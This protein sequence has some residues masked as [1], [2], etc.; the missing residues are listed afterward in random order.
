MSRPRLLDLFCCE[1]GASRGFELAGFQVY[2]VDIGEWSKK[3]E[4]WNLGPLKRYPYPHHHGDALVVMR[5]LLLGEAIPFTH[6]DGSVEWLTLA[7][8]AVIAGSPPCQAYSQTKHTH[9]VVHPELIEPTR[10]LL[11]ESG[12]PYVIENVPN[13]PLIE[14]LV[15]CGTEFNLRAHDPDRGQVVALRRHRLFESNVFLVGAGGCSCAQDRAK[16]RIAGVYGAGAR[17]VDA[18]KIRKGGY[19]GAKATSAAL[20]GIDWMTMH[21]LQQSIP[22]VYTRHIGE[23]IMAALELEAAS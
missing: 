13:A 11:V 6:P 1:G 2:G 17:S 18:A 4:R 19:T 5:R 15:L 9:Q 10:A 3:T 20:L 7:D 8:F 23:Q 22:P 14:P 21:G 12:L 16:G